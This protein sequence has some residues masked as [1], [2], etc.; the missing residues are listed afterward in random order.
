M[1]AKFAIAKTY[2]TFFAMKKI[3]LL[4]ILGILTFGISYADNDGSKNEGT[5]SMTLVKSQHNGRPNAPSRYVIECEYNSS[6]IKF[7][8]PPF[9]E[10]IDVEFENEEGIA[11]ECFVPASDPVVSIPSL[12]GTYIIRCTTDGGSVYEGIIEL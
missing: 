8:L 7:M 9:V 11:F 1:S 4:L 6:F 3:C 12:I 10:S 2:K 5:S